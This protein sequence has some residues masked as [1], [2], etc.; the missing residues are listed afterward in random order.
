M[1]GIRVCDECYDD[2]HPQEFPISVSDPQALWKPAPDEVKF[3]APT[4]A[5][6]ITAVTNFRLSWSSANFSPYQSAGYDLYRDVGAG[7]VLR[8]AL[9]NTGDFL[10]TKS[11]ETLVFIDAAPPASS[12]SYR[13]DARD[14]LG[15]VLPS[16]VVI[17]SN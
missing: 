6:A 12:Y 10:G 2:R 5:W 9:N 7:F 4:L 8:V 15:N 3:T 17:A 16:N 1:P 14:V 13:I 11:I